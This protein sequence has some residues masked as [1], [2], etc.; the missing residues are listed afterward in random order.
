MNDQRPHVLYGQKHWALAHC[1]V[2][3]SLMNDQRPHVLYRQKTWALAHFQLSEF[4]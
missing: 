3:W 2:K 4:V 1:T